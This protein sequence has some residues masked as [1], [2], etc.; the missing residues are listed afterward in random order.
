MWSEALAQTAAFITT[1]SQAVHEAHVQRAY[2]DPLLVQ[3]LGELTVDVRAAE[4]A[5]R[6][7]SGA[8]TESLLNPSQPAATEAAV[9]VA[10]V[11]V[12]GERAAL[13]VTSA[14]FELGGPP[15][16]AA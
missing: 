6:I 12:L 1:A 2:D 4:A 10:T 13:A 11:K 3:R 9:A 8:P 5:L 16:A 15:A 7:A 14:A